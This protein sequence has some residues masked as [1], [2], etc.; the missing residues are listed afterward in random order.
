MDVINAQ[1]LLFNYV[2]P[3]DF[4]NN[5]IYAGALP[6]YLLLLATL[7]LSTLRVIVFFTWA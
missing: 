7:N 1:K 2:L 5:I 4:A 3:C 6:W